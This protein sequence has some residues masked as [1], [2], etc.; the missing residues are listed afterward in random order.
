MNELVFLQNNQALTT[1][2]TVAKYF[3]KR[4][5][6]VL[7]AIT[8]SIQALPKNGGSE[9]AFIKSTYKD[10]TGKSNPMYL[11]NRDGFIFV[12]MKFTGAKAA[13]W[14]WNFIQEFNRMEQKISRLMAE[15]EAGLWLDARN[16]TK[17]GYKALSAAGRRLYEYAV[18]HGYTKPERFFYMN[19]ARLMNKTLGINPKSRDTLQLWQLFEIEKMQHIAKTI[20]DGLISQGAD[21]HV[22]YK[23]C[24]TIFENYARLSHFEERFLP[25]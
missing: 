12:A 11:L 17:D 20:I 14:Q 15:R 6:K 19:F 10:E 5:D 25:A 2:L 8:A 18:E 24:Q 4:H 1:S 9:K 3:E 23:Q 21:C 22:P 7:R 13:Q 16:A